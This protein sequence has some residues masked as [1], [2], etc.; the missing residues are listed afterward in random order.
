MYFEVNFEAESGDHSDED[1][2]VCN[3]DI[4]SSGSGTSTRSSN[5]LDFIDLG[6]SARVLPAVYNGGVSV[7][8]PISLPFGY[9]Q[10]T[11]VFVSANRLSLL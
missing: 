9:L 2:G 8:L 11:T 6:G 4:S 10:F 5:N 7:N 1:C 3:S